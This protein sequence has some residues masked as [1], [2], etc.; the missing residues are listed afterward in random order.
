MYTTSTSHADPETLDK[1]RQSASPQASWEMLDIA[2]GTGYTAFAFAPHVRHI[3]GIDL[4]PQMLAE[5]EKLRIT[6]KIENVEFRVGDVH[7]LPFSDNTFDLIT[8]RR[9]AHHFTN[10]SQALHE[11]AR[12]LKSHQFL[13]IVDRSIPDNDFV[14]QAM[15]GLDVLHD[16]SHVREYR[17]S[18]WQSLLTT[19]GFQVETMELYIQHRPLT[20]L[21]D[22]V[23]PENVAQIHALIDLMTPAEKELM[24]IRGINGELYINHW[25]ILIK[26]KKS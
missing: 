23:S 19:A 6:K 16:A 5:A 9:A 25:F 7:V 18:E 10:I 14:D 20:S 4:T 17:K 11:M 22:R 12:V 2:T 26:T 1:L 24:N 15:N 21:T 3:I 8:C 13:V